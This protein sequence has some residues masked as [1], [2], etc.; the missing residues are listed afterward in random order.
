MYDI[1]ISKL[2]DLKSSKTWISL[3][4]P[5]GYFLP[6]SVKVSDK[7]LCK[8]F[9]KIPVRVRGIWSAVNISPQETKNQRLPILKRKK[10]YLLWR[11]WALE[12]KKNKLRH[13][14]STLK[15][16]HGCVLQW[17]MQILA[18]NSLLRFLSS[19]LSFLFKIWARSNSEFL[20]CLFG[21][22]FMNFWLSSCL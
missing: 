4:V 7:S 19:F 21:F 9:F 6:S 16:V 2:S 3:I 17:K 5:F 14:C 13:T 11:L 10:D 22:C 15:N 18:Q 12:G 1:Y 20:F 8:S